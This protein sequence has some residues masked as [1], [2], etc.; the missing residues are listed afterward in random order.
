ML[1]EKR[2]ARAE[3]LGKHIAI[4]GDTVRTTAK[5]FGFSKSTVHTAVTIQNGLC[6]W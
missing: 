2:I 1:R 3:I 6:G 4:T 5:I